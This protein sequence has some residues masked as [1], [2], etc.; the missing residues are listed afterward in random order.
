MGGWDAGMEVWRQGV[1][2]I[3]P[4]FMSSTP[5][6]GLLS[7]GTPRSRALPFSFHPSVSCVQQQMH[8]YEPM[9]SCM[10][11]MVAC[12]LESDS[13][14]RGVWQRAH[15]SPVVLPAL[16]RSGPSFWVPLTSIMQSSA[17]RQ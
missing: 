13:A 1:H 4:F 12:N 15:P 2:F 7:S 3:T 8:S 11:F 10:L 6:S 14:A 9:G 16:P 5:R 17:S